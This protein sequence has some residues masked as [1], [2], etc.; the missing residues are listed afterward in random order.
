VLAAAAALDYRPSRLGRSLAR[1]HHEATG[2]VFP[3]LS[4]PYY[5]AIILGY[6]EAS[7]AEG[8]GSLWSTKA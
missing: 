4:G 2:I 8:N 6:E 7:A 1:G 5:S 3:D